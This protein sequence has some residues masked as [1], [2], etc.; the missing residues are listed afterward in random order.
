MPID[1]DPLDRVRLLRL[2]HLARKHALT[3]CA[4]SYLALAI[5]ESLSLATSDGALKRAALAEGVQLL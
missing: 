3:T 1:V 2:P 5:R 4:A